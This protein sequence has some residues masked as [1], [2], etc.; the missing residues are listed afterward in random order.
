MSIITYYI[1][2]LLSTVI[3]HWQWYHMYHKKCKWTDMVKDAGLLDFSG[4]F[5][6]CPVNPSSLSNQLYDNLK[7]N[8]NNVE[9]FADLP[10]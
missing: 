4:K 7:K 1:H 10:V 5:L 3:T 6:I 8:Q 2:T 9:L